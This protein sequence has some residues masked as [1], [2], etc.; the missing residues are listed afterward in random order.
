[1]GRSANLCNVA[2]KAHPMT[3]KM[4]EVYFWRLQG[5]KKTNLVVGCKALQ[6]V[7]T[8]RKALQT[9]ASGCK[10][11]LTSANHCKGVQTT[12]NGCIREV[13]HYYCP[14]NRVIEM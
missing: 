3:A 8:D 7:A 2:A 14:G 6:T 5:A 4:V 11:G 10:T 1:M 12:A 13:R 9:I